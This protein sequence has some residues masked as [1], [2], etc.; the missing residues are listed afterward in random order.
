MVMVDLS[1]QVYI[2][3]FDKCPWNISH[4]SAVQTDNLNIINTYHRY[5]H[6]YQLFLEIPVTYW[7]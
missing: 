1:Y 6:G 2:H 4:I 3:V 5:E 7:I